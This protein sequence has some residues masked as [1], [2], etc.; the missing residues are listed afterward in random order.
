MGGYIKGAVPRGDEWGRAMRGP[1]WQRLLKVGVGFCGPGAEVRAGVR[2]G[3]G[4]W[5]GS[6]AVC[7]FLL[8]GSGQQVVCLADRFV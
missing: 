3:L 2:V 5:L 4:D 8:G 6:L 7:M 1:T